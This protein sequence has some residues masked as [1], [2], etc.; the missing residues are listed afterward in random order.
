MNIRQ[1]VVAT[2][3]LFGTAQ[4]QAWKPNPYRQK[5]TFAQKGKDQKETRREIKARRKEIAI[6]RAVLAQ[7]G[8]TE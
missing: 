3:V 8:Q 2:I 4:M 7:T 5:K 6:A 1:L